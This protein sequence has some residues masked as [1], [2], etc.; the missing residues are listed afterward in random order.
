MSATAFSYLFLGIGLG[1][2]ILATAII[3]PERR[4]L[5][6]ALAAG[7][8]VALANFLVEV[9]GARLGIYHVSGALAVAGSPVSLCIAW[10]LLG[11]SYCLG[12]GLLT[13]IA[14]PTRTATLL[15]LIAGILLGFI[16][17]YCAAKFLPVLRLG[18]RGKPYHIAFVWI[19]LIPLTILYYR[20]ILSTRLTAPSA[21]HR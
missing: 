5:N 19:T 3:R 15:Y 21:A 10:F 20:I 2:A 9:T 17:D 6:G 4:Q 7:G 11:Y 8:F 16:Y 13:R 18:A 1:T 14:R 12:Y